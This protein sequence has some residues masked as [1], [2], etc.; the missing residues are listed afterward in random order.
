MILNLEHLPRV[1]PVGIQT[2][3]GVETIGFD[4]SP[5]MT[6]W[7]DLTF[8]VWPTRPGESASY[9][10]ADTELVGNVLYWYP[11]SADTEKE[12]AGTVEVVGIGGGKCK[13]S[14][15]IDT[16]VKKTS[17]DVTQETPEPMKLWADK[18]LQAANE[19]KAS[20]DTGEG[21]LYLIQQIGSEID[22]TYD[23]IDAAINAK[24]TCI[25]TDTLGRVHLY[26]NRN[27]EGTLIFR[28]IEHG[29]PISGGAYTSLTER[30]V[31]IDKNG[32]VSSIA[33]S[34]INA[35]NP[36]ALTI[37]Q[38][39]QTVTY[40]GKK[41]VN[42]KIEG[43]GSI[44]DPG[45]A[46][47]QL[48]SD[49]DGKAVWQEQI[50][51]KYAQSGTMTLF[52]EETLMNGEGE[53]EGN[54]FF[55]ATPLAAIPEVG[56]TYE[57]T[58]NGTVYNTIAH[59][60]EENGALMGV[61]L[62]NPAFVGL[63]DN[64]EPYVLVAVLPEYQAMTGGMTLIMMSDLGVTPITLSIKGQATI[65]TI[66]KIDPDLLPDT[67]KTIT[68]MI[69][70]DGNAMCD[71]PFAEVSKMT[72]GELQSALKI[73]QTGSYGGQPSELEA[74]VQVRRRKVELLGEILEIT[75]RQYTDPGDAAAVRETTR[76][77]YWAASGLQLAKFSLSSLPVMDANWGFDRQTY[78]LRS[79]G[80]KWQPVSIEQMKQ[81]LGIGGGAEPATTDVFYT[82]DGQVFTTLEGAVMH[83]QK[84]E[85]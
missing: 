57:V 21:A 79:V 53:D 65:T 61:V 43:G 29:V 84:G 41:A 40:D 62:G 37:E 67:Q 73:V 54:V 58:I 11:N 81:D 64:G 17:L 83:V 70:A 44:P 47:Q 20:V 51:Y 16:L 77:I 56:K 8:A 32:K 59:P 31:H 13:S 24:K 7:P 80:G 35:P 28:A 50:A 39:G 3:S 82:A 2:E 69:D 12:G 38:N 48:V 78:Y 10:A 55:S 1:I 75:F 33:I 15:V 49:A 36:K 60:M 42:I 23:E 68:I 19:V 5:W 4:L 30:E 14:G 18:V 34:P 52:T 71:T 9:I 45:K 76:Y 26:S 85:Q 66:K 72:C 27:S 22:R 6:R 74:D 46:F 63:E 25:L